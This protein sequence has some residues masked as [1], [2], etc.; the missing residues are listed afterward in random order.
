MKFDY[1]R[2]DMLEIINDTN[3]GIVRIADIVNGL[4]SFSR[5]N[6]IEKR[7]LFNLNEGI[8]T[9][10][11]I[12]NNEL[13]YNS[14]VEFIENKI[15][16]IEVDGGQI[17]QVI[18]NIL[19]NASHAIKNKFNNG[20]KGKIKIETIE[21]ENNVYFKIEDN[22][23]G[24]DKEIK[25]K[26]YEPFF[27]TKPEGEGTGLGLGIV[28]DIIVNKHKGDIKVESEL[29]KGTKFEIALPKGKVI[30]EE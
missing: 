23:C 18:L 15:S 6:R 24:M 16:N 25:N 28:Y 17:N 5:I 21:D 30:K 22:G 19:V 26:I 7:T 13:K 9:T 2:E 4:K 8:K 11:L 29:N 14:D 1:I 10:L 3:E 12:A 27:T 20:E